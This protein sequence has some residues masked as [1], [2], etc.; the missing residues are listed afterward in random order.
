MKLFELAYA[1]LV[2]IHGTRNYLDKYLLIL[3]VMTYSAGK[4]AEAE[5]N[6]RLQTQGMKILAAEELTGLKVEFAEKV[7]LHYFL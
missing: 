5:G 1:Q 2:K 7:M 3:G 4:G 6:I